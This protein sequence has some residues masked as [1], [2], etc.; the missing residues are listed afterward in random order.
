MSAE[1]VA[2]LIRQ[3]VDANTSLEAPASSVQVRALTNYFSNPKYIDIGTLLL[4]GLPGR[5]HLAAKTQQA[6]H[7]VECEISFVR[8]IF[9]PTSNYSSSTPLQLS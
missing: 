6:H 3:T 2:K 5:M 7:T 8:I 1:Y 4:F 9:K